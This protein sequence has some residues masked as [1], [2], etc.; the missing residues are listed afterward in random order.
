V[1]TSERVTVDASRSE[2]AD[3]YR[4]DFDGDERTDA[5]GITAGWTYEEPG[6]KEIDLYVAE[7]NGENDSLVRTITVQA[8]STTATPT[9]TAESTT[10]P[11]AMSTPTRTSTPSP[12]ATENGSGA[13]AGSGG[14]SD[15]DDS[16]ESSTTTSPN[17]SYTLAELRQDGQHP[18]D[19][20][21]S[22]RQA[23]DR[24]VWLIH[25]P[26]KALWANVG[27][28]QDDERQFVGEGDAVSRNSV[29]LRTINTGG[30]G[31]LT[32]RVVSY[33]VEERTVETDSGVTTKE[34]ITGLEE[35]TVDVSLSAGWSTA[36]IPLP[37]LDED[38]NVL[39]YAESAPETLRWTFRHEP[40]ATSQAAA[41]STEGDYLWRL[42]TDVFIP[43]LIGLLIIGALARKAI[44]RAGAGPQWGL[45]QWAGLIA[46]SGFVGYLFGPV[47]STADLLVYLPTTL[48]ILLVAVAGIV[49]LE[50]WEDGAQDVLFIKPDVKPVV[51]AGGKEARDAIV[52]AADDELVVDMPDGSTAIV[53]SGPMK[54][55]ARVFGSAAKVRNAD[56]MKTAVELE[57]SQ[58]DQLVFVAPDD[59]KPDLED[60]P[61][62]DIDDLE[63]L[64]D[65]D[66]RLDDWERDP[67]SAISYRPEGWELTAPDLSTWDGR[68]K[69]LAIGAALAAGSVAIYGWLG[70]LF[71]AGVGAAGTAVWLAEPV[72]GAATF[73]PA[74]G[75]LRSAMITAMV[76][77]SDVADAE[78][79]DEARQQNIE[80]RSQSERDVEEALAK[81]DST[82]LEA[83]LRGGTDGD[84]LERSVV[85]G[86]DVDGESGDGSDG[87]GDGD[88]TGISLKD[89]EAA[90]D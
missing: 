12:T 5:S 39:I 26:A 85:E 59:H 50:S 87:G 88:E 51:S 79:L 41:I 3:I 25:W 47:E 48:A 14:G 68:F 20:P 63:E 34:V 65:Q 10:T 52:S 22:V 7:Q 56:V 61:T 24:M 83:L 89:G 49:L 60:E 38:R 75:H 32:L 57:G 55:L 76:M 80:L 2:N 53:R 66:G 27:D 73:Q 9:T 6:S 74:P 40:V 44:Q 28:P 19:A 78:T 82:L 72:P 30:G 37:R 77:S 81:Q 84:P 21:P 67:S 31:D 16:S 90:D 11:T 17:G 8:Q 58:H 62:A 35:R 86:L 36:E 13:A 46:I 29:Y 1:N 54:F 18:S 15:S 69:T 64:D 45:G 43:T 4:W 23:G 33:K 70:P 42:A 71:A